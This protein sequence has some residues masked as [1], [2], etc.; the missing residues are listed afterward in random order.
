MCFC[1]LCWSY[2]LCLQK[3]AVQGSSSAWFTVYGQKE[4]DDHRACTY[5][6]QNNLL[7]S[8][9]SIL[10]IFGFQL[11]KNQEIPSHFWEEARM[12]DWK[13]W[14]TSNWWIAQNWYCLELFILGDLL[15]TK[16][17]CFVQCIGTSERLYSVPQKNK[18]K[19]LLG[20]R[21]WWGNR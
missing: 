20:S 4:Q 18:T 7:Y 14:G 1:V 8:C 17:V 3:F 5:I 6:I 16:E 9:I 19:F 12:N 10:I 11:M 21:K 15:Q 2:Q 13:G